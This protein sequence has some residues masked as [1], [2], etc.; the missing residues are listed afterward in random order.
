MNKNICVKFAEKSDL[1]RLVKAADEVLR[2]LKKR[3]KGDMYGGNDESEFLEVLGGKIEG[4]CIVAKE[5]DRIIGYLVLNTHNENT[6]K[7]RF[8]DYGNGDELC[9]DGMGVIPQY[10]E[11]GIAK[12]MI[13]YAKLYLM[14]IEKKYFFGTIHPENYQSILCI[15]KTTK[16]FKISEKTEIYEMKDGRKLERKYFLTEI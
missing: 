10:Q 3:G 12:E 14:L 15:A 13:E 4:T 7:E 1:S 11:K 16:K 2:D 9:I 8:K 5:E 6:C